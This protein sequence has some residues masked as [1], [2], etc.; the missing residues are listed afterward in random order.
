MNQSKL[1]IF[2][3]G[4]AMG[5]AD[6]VPGVS[7]G[8]IA[9]IT[10]IYARLIAAIASVGPSTLSLLLRGRVS[11]AWKAID[12]PFLLVLGAG[13][14]T[15]VIGLASLLDWLVQHFPLPL[16]AAFA[17]LVLASALSLVKQNYRLWS[18]KEWTLFII[19]IAVAVFV[20]LT[21]AVQLPITPWGVFLAGSVAICAMILPGISGSFLLLLMGMYQVVISAVVNLELVTLGLFALGCG[22]GILLFSR[23]LQR[24]LLVAEQRVMA[25]LLGFLLGSLIILWPWQVTVSS[26]LDRHGEMRA[27]QTLP[28]TPG[29]YAE[30]VGDPMLLLSLVGFITGFVSVQLLMFLSREQDD[31]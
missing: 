28:V 16:W 23:L 6:L 9:L 29:H 3:R 20:G 22:M 24:L 4:V 31:S 27:V 12:G 18:S 5:A 8:T 11:D 17:G 15:A 10:G 1:G 26:V 14:A 2:L 25:M 13:I 7:G 19:G 30:Q 21:Q